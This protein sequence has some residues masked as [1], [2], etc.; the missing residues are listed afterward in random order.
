MAIQ[1]RVS[2]CCW[3][4]GFGK[5]KAKKDVFVGF[6]NWMLDS[7][8]QMTKDLTYAPLPAEVAA[9]VRATIKQIQ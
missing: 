2:H 3:C 1:L 5:T 7:G 6:P 4:R 8:E 9:R